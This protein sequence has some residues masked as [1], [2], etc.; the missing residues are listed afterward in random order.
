VNDSLEDKR[1]QQRG[2]KP[3]NPDVPKG[4]AANAFHELPAAINHGARLEVGVRSAVGRSWGSAQLARDGLRRW[5]HDNH[6]RD[7]R[8]LCSDQ[9]VEVLQGLDVC[10]DYSGLGFSSTMLDNKQKIKK[11]RGG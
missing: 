1:V 8:R 9:H 3:G 5:N 11:F 2:N 4:P 10:V 7:R 6:W